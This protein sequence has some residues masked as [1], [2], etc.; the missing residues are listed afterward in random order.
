MSSD[1]ERLERLLIQHLQREHGPNDRPDERA[2][3]E[4]AAEAEVHESASVM[5]DHGRGRR[6]DRQGE[7]N[8]HRQILVRHTRGQE[9]RH[10]QEATAEAQVRVD[11]RHPENQDGLNQEQ[12]RVHATRK[13]VPY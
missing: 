2:G 12:D 1:E 8:R 4:D 5:V 11:E 3:Q 9:N 13:S 6:R 7:G 10:E